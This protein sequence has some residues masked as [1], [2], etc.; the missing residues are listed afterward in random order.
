MTSRTVI[1]PH[2]GRVEGDGGIHVS[3]SDTRVSG[4]LLRYRVLSLSADLL[5]QL[6]L[7]TGDV[8]TLDLAN[9]RVLGAG[10]RV[11]PVHAQAT[12]PVIPV[13]CVEERARRVGDRRAQADLRALDAD[14]NSVV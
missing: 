10:G 3:L 9:G 4:L 5:P 14:R 8:V 7:D 13:G 12:G 11:D 1:I 2:L 6:T